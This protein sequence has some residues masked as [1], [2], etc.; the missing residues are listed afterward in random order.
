MKYVKSAHPTQLTFTGRAERIT[1]LLEIADIHPGASVLD[2]GCGYGDVS[3]GLAKT[4][5]CV[6]GSDI[7]LPGVRAAQ[8]VSSGMRLDAM[9]VMSPVESLAVRDHSFPVAICY[10]IWE[11]VQDPNAL[12][13]QIRR[14]LQE[15]G[16]LF[17]V[18][19]NRFWILESHYR[20]PFLSW[21]PQ[22]LADVYLRVCGR[23]RKYD[24]DCP[25]WWELASSLEKSGFR[26]NN[27]NLHVLRNFNRLYPSPEYLGNTKY[28]I[29]R[30]VSLFLGFLPRSIGQL[31]SD[32]FSEAFFVIATINSAEKAGSN[33]KA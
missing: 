1:Q 30:I 25:T 28:R 24:V 6:I 27:L 4:G 13:R 3:L 18:V 17:M 9:F 11:H 15:D 31:L 22:H 21:V 2:I 19:P 23:G 16:V 7:F 5:F 32:L 10:N 12:L 20:L 26:V 8:R 14:I 33:G 29:G